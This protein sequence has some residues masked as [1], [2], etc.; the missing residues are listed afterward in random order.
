MCVY[1]YKYGARPH[2]CYPR[3][4]HATRELTETGEEKRGFRCEVPRKR[5]KLGGTRDGSAHTY[6]YTKRTT[7]ME[8][9]QMLYVNMEQMSW[10]YGGPASQKSKPEN[11]ELNRPSRSYCWSH[12]AA[13]KQVRRKSHPQISINQFDI[14]KQGFSGGGFCGRCEKRKFFPSSRAGNLVNQVWQGQGL[15][16]KIRICT[17]SETWGRIKFR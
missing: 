12:V 11:S 16:W 6:I 17:P 3:E 15:K 14:K 13:A 9:A 1:I 2:K 7:L 10:D 5:K 8:H 4:W